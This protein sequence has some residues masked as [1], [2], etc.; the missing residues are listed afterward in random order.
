MGPALLEEY[1]ALHPPQTGPGVALQRRRAV[2]KTSP[3][4]E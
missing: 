1:R 4:T 3:K 2:N